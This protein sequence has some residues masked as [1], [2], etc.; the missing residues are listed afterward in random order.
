MLMW[1]YKKNTMRDRDRGGYSEDVVRVVT[2]EI[3]ELLSN[4][5]FELGSLGG[6]PILT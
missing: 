5:R 1:D 6:P 2:E 3:K 4:G